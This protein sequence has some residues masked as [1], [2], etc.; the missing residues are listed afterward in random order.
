MYFLTIFLF[1]H[2][3]CLSREPC[4][5]ALGLIQTFHLNFV[6]SCSLRLSALRVTQI[7]CFESNEMLHSV[8][9]G[10]RECIK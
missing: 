9:W 3:R 6:Q 4:Y 5:A 7:V 8:V 10:K 2:K 1:V